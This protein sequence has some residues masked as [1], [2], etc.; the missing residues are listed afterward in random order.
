MSLVV[1]RPSL[2]ADD[3]FSLARQLLNWEPVATR[4]VTNWVP[5]FEVKETANAYTVRGDVPGVEEKDLEVTVHNN[6]LSIT[7][8]RNAEQ[9]QEGESYS[10]Y[11]RQFGSFTRRFALPENADGDKIEAKLAHGVLT[12]T[13]PKKAELQPR[14]IAFSK[15]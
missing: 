12:L 1:R 5:A 2:F 3:P 6:V 14:K 10:V 15:Q 4:A 11:E 13:V 8:T 7:A 9:A